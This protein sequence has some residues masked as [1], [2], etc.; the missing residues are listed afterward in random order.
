MALLTTS[1]HTLFDRSAARH[2]LHA[3]DFRRAKPRAATQVARS[4]NPGRGDPWAGHNT[5]AS[6]RARHAAA[7]PPHEGTRVEFWLADGAQKSRGGTELKGDLVSPAARAAHFARRPC[8]A[9]RACWTCCRRSMTATLW[10]RCGGREHGSSLRATHACC[11][12]VLHGACMPH[13]TQVMD[14]EEWR[15]HRTFTHRYSLRPGQL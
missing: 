2:A 7:R 8:R 12:R 15:R 3:Y 4:Q 11:T 1:P 9:P 14:A 10:I 13:L 5:P 6:S